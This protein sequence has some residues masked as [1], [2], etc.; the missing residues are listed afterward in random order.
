ME[1]NRTSLVV[2]WFEDPPASVGTQ[3][4]PLLQDAEAWSYMLWDP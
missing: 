4:Q 1:N 2:R 3:V